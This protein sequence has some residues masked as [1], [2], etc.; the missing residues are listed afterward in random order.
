MYLGW[1]PG[2]RKEL[3]KL[4]NELV[5]G[6]CIH[7]GGSSTV[8]LTVQTDIWLRMR[9]GRQKPGLCKGLPKAIVKDCRRKLT[10]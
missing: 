5:M 3:W 7:S 10:V 2:Y 6:E 8:M 1:Q 4:E 9:G